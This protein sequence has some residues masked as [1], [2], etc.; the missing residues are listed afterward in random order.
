MQPLFKTFKINL[1][2]SFVHSFDLKFYFQ[3]FINF[4]AVLFQASLV[5]IQQ[6]KRRLILKLYSKYSHIYCFV[7]ILT[8]LLL[9]SPSKLQAI[10]AD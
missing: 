8:L 6:S 1:N 7:L 10:I 9:S 2:P 5:C 4:C 3:P